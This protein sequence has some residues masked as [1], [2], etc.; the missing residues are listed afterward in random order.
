MKKDMALIITIKY[1]IMDLNLKKW[2]ILPGIPLGVLDIF[3]AR[4]V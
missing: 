4:N 3:N 1:E 2:F